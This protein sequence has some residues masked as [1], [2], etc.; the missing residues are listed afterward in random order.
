[1][2][3]PDNW[4]VFTPKD[5]LAGWLEMYVRVME[6]DYWTSARATRASY[7]EGEKI[8]RVVVERERRRIELRPRHL[9]FATGA[10][11]PLREPV[12]EGADE[13][14]GEILHSSRYKTGREYEGKA[15]LVVGTNSSAHDV[16]ADLWDFGADVTMLQRSS[17]T[18]VRSERLPASGSISARTSLACR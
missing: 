9:I 14:G 16:A 5:K 10:Y 13:F 7:D 12:F 11:G 15:V 6:L 2:P 1:M 17:T 8:W 3:F 18:V 4:P